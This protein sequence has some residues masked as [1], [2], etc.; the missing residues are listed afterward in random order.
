[1]A[2]RRIS[3]AA[4]P[5]S[6]SACREKALRLLTIRSRSRQELASA[7]KLRGFD[8]L[9]ISSTLDSLEQS[10]S[11]SDASALESF[12]RAHGERYGRERLRQELKRR[13]FSEEMIAEAFDERSTETER[14]TFERFLERAAKR[15]AGLP[16][17]RRKARLFA[18][19]RRRGFPDEWIREAIDRVRE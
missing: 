7:L 19:L 11:Q 2:T 15:V 16:A 9:T 14:G 3:R 5:S 4:D 8:A 12:L 6:E 10:G 17:Q 13:G 18:S 1:M